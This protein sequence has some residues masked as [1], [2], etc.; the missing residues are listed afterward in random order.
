M[1]KTSLIGLLLTVWIQA[2]FA[3]VDFHRLGKWQ[4][5]GEV[6]SFSPGKLWEIIDG[7]AELYLAY[8]VQEL[9][10]CDLT[11]EDTA[12]TVM[13]FDMSTPLNAFGI[14]GIEKPGE[15]TLPIG[16][17]SCL[18]PPYQGL[19]LKDRFYV[20][21]DAYAGELNARA[22]SELLA[23]L[24]AQLPGSTDPPAELIQL[25]VSGRIAGTEGYVAQG[26]LGL[27]DLNHCLHATCELGEGRSYQ[28][29]LVFPAIGQ[30]VA[31]TWS[32]LAK[33]W[34]PTSGAAGP[35]L[36]RSIPYR[37]LAGLTLTSAGILGVA[38]AENQDELLAAFTELAVSP[39]GSSIAGKE[40]PE[41]DPSR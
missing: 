25:P 28:V 37:G 20:K 8:E 7:A 18:T 1:K 30:T 41:K 36:V 10:V 6:A 38:G 12:V 31:S 33:T 5:A 23:A 35:T 22:G 27:K 34:Q 2:G 24:S 32:H 19:L 39:L 9:Q 15:A 26:Y 14:F 40:K 16:T 4:P 17:A 29:F 21:V 11:T 3:G 13:I